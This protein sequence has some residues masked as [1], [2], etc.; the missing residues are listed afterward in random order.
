MT[1]M[2]RELGHDIDYSERYEYCKIITI[3]CVMAMV[4]S[5]QFQQFFQLTKTF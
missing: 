4:L 2:S 5:S 3:V 1:D